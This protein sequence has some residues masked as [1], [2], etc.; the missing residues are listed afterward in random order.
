MPQL[1]YMVRRHLCASLSM[2]TIWVDSSACLRGFLALSLP[3]PSL[4][5]LSQSLSSLSLLSLCSRNVQHTQLSATQ[6][7]SHPQGP[8]RE[9][10]RVTVKGS[11]VWSCVCVCVCVKCCL[12]PFHYEWGMEERGAS[13]LPFSILWTTF[14]PFLQ[15]YYNQCQSLD[16]SKS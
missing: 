12:R 3:L 14:L 13:G 9:G 2:N 5:S 8:L 11:S 10:H 15:H 6:H 7:F 16:P 4:L 1:Q